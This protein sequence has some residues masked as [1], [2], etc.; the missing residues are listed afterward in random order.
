MCLTF[1]KLIFPFAV[2]SHSKNPSSLHVINRLVF[3]AVTLTVLNQLCFWMSHTWT[4]GRQPLTPEVWLRSQWDCGEQCGIGTSSF[5][6]SVPVCMS[7]CHSTLLH[8]LF[9][10]TLYLHCMLHYKWVT[11]HALLLHISTVLYLSSYIVFTYYPILVCLGRLLITLFFIQY[12]T[13]RELFK[14]FVVF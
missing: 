6:L 2:I 1:H 3:A 9:L 7:V 4:R 12:Y 14:V 10:F 8:T 5:L 11:L 13:V